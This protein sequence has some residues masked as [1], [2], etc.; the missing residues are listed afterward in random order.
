VGHRT[1]GR[2]AARGSPANANR[3]R[4]KQ[5]LNSLLAIPGRAKREPGMTEKILRNQ[6]NCP[7]G[8]SLSDIRK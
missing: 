7:T 3:G 5:R 1:S 8:K 4:F 6:Q 2:R